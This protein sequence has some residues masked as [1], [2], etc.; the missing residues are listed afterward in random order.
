[1]TSN[2]FCQVLESRISGQI[3]DTSGASVPGA[4]IRVTEESTGLVRNATSGADGLYAVQQ[5]RLISLADRGLLAGS[6]VGGGEVPRQRCQV[7]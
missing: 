6:R 2:A 5:L 4:Q 3:K 1:M 7:F